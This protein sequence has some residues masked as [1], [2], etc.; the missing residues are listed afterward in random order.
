MQYHMA[1][2]L[3]RIQRWLLVIKSL[4]E[5]HN[6]VV[7]FSG[8]HPN[9]YMAY[10]YIT[11]E[12]EDTVHSADH[13]V[14]I[15]NT[16]APREKITGWEPEAGSQEFCRNREILFLNKSQIS[17]KKITLWRKYH[18]QT[19]TMYALLRCYVRTWRPWMS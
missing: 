18:I 19:V 5:A 9:Y 1:I 7:H 10:R 17:Y 15:N 11:K 3:Y 14:L 8:P 16:M 13:P 6:I 4:E 2:K 12:D